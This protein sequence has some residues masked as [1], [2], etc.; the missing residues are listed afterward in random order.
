MSEELMSKNLLHQ[1]ALSESVA[2]ASFAAVLAGGIA[3]IVLSIIGLSHYAPILMAAIATLALGTAFALNG[4]LLALGWAHR[5]QSHARGETAEYLGGLSAEAVTGVAAIVLAILALLNVDA[6]ALLPVATLVLGIGA[7][8]G[9][10]MLAW[11][12]SANRTTS[13]RFGERT[14]QAQPASAVLAFAAVVEVLAGLGAIALSILALIGFLPLELSLV[15]LL[16]LGVAN[17]LCGASVAGR[18][19]AH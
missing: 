14:D 11:L 19:L 16:A 1:G 8:F 4:G 17:V 5:T 18:N 6:A 2:S 12:N 9:S 13:T 15:A 3:A 10:G 7:I